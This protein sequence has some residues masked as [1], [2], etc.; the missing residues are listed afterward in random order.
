MLLG[1]TL[2]T[3]LAVKHQSTVLIWDG[4]LFCQYKHTVVQEDRIFYKH[5]V[6]QEDRIFIIKC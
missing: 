5:T 2:E 3:V 6:V 4:L 1:T